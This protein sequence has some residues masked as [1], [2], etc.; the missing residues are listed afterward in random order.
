MSYGGEEPS[1]QVRYARDEFFAVVD[2]DA[3]Q[4]DWQGWREAMGYD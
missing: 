4:F 3:D 2:I 1:A